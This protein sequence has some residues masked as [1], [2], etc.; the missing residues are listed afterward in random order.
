M[1]VCTECVI[2][3]TTKLILMKVSLKDTLTPEN[4]R[5]YLLFIVFSRGSD[6]YEYNFN[7]L[8]SL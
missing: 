8:L 6:R 4:Q 3:E 7:N 5:T 2:F 1:Y